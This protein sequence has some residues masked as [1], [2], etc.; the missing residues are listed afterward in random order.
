VFD[1]F[2][3]GLLDSECFV[4]RVDV[5]HAVA[6]EGGFRHEEYDED[7]HEYESSAHGVHSCAV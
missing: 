6:R 2:F 3:L 4:A 7:K 5:E 1:A